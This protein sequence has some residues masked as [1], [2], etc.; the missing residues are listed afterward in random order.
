MNDHSMCNYFSYQRTCQWLGLFLVFIFPA[1]GAS[2]P[3]FKKT[4]ELFEQKIPLFVLDKN[5]NITLSQLNIQWNPQIETTS[6]TINF[7]FDGAMSPETTQSLSQQLWPATLASAILWQQPW[8]NA[9]WVLSELSGA[10]DSESCASLSLGLLATA[11]GIDYPQDT[12]LLATLLPDQSLGPVQNVESRMELAVNTGIKKIILSD[13]QHLDR[14]HPNKLLDTAAK[15]KTLKL[16]VF[17][18]QNLAEAAEIALDHSLPSATWNTTPCRYSNSTFS[19]LAQRCQNQI[20]E[21]L[22]TKNLWP[23]TQALQQLSPWEQAIWQRALSLFEQG[24]QAYQA[25]QVYAAYRLLIDASSEIAATQAFKTNLNSAQLKSFVTQTS[26]L[27]DDVIQKT[28]DK[29]WDKNDLSLSLFLSERNDWLLTLQTKL[30]GPLAIARQAWHSQSD[31]TEDE[32]KRAAILLMSGFY[33]VTYQTQ[34]RDI[35]PVFQRNFKKSDS[36]AFSHRATDWLNQLTPA[37][38]AKGESF[39]GQIKQRASQWQSSLIWDTR[40]ASQTTLLQRIK[41][42]WEKKWET[43]QIPRALLANAGFTPGPAYRPP[44][45]QPTS[46]ASFAFN[47]VAQCFLDINYFLETDLLKEKYFYWNASLKLDSLKW[48]LSNRL[49]LEK[50]LQ[51]AEITAR[52][53]M[54][55]AQNVDID[56][57]PLAMIY[58]YATVL[59][60]SPDDQDRMEALRQ[61]W[62]CYWLGSLSQQLGYIPQATIYSQESSSPPQEQPLPATEEISE[63]TLEEATQ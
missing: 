35:F 32:K 57:S 42:S 52:Q 29:E 54:A 50:M 24:S 39:T 58:E 6:E 18:A 36:S 16:K 4:E 17:Y 62:R 51:N 40:L 56:T 19:F 53:G 47:D 43:H 44:Q 31:A 10:I 30:E 21:L 23:S 3:L 38:L 22:R 60:M 26:S 41:R 61:F 12:L 13:N 14:T 5:S 2:L 46:A 34:L 9:D 20:N 63:G 33:Y 45:P 8:Q 15:A 49:A 25:G 59:K 7:R 48:S 11:C 28:Q 1:H 27:L 55:A 37:L